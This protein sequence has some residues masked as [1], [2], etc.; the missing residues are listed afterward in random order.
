[1]TEFSAGSWLVL[2]AGIAAIAW[3]NWY[4]FFAGRVSGA[5]VPPDAGTVSINGETA[6]VTI[7]VE[8]GYSPSTIHLQA[9]Q[10]ARMIF[11]RRENSSCS[12]EVVIPA[13]QVKRFLPAFEKTALDIT[14]PATAGTYPFTC[15]MGMLKGRIIVDGEQ[16][17][18]PATEVR[19]HT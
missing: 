1:M 8:G 18:A 6:E 10:K 4:F 12:E 17:S 19:E 2:A 7:V 11:D 5:K 16:M 3:V 9:G 14:A 13:L 15:G